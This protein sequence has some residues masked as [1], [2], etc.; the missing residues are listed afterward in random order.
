MSIP[1]RAVDHPE[2]M[3]SRYVTLSKTWDNPK[4]HILVTRDGIQLDM[5]LEEFTAAVISKI[6]ATTFWK[7]WLFVLG[8]GP[9]KQKYIEDTLRSCIDR[10]V[11]EMKQ[12][13]GKVL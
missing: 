3:I 13:T 5:P 7:N 2:E 1:I 8:N 9:D 6:E 4:I 12:V 11:E 10:T